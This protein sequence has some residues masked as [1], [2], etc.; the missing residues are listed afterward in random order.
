M[1][2]IWTE[3]YRPET[4]KDV[5]GQDKITN[6]L[7]SFVKKKS[8]PHLMFSGPPGIGKTT[9][10]MCI[11]KDLWGEN[12]KSNF[13]ETNASDERGINVIREKIK[14]NA[15]IKPLASE[16]KIIFLDECDA[17]TKD[18]QQALRR[19]M[20]QYTST[21]R[22]V[23]SCNYSSNII[24]PIQSRCAVF[25]FKKIESKDIAKDIK[26]IAGEENLEIDD[27]AVEMIT[28][29]SEGDIRNAINLLQCTAIEG[30]KIT[31]K[32]VSEISATLM[33][34]EVADIINH[35]LNKDFLKSR[36]ML[37]GMMIEKGI[38][39]FEI[40]RAINRHVWALDIEDELKVKIIKLLGEFEFRIASGGSED[41]QIEA[42]LANLA[43]LK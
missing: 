34:S 36:K 20:E 11:A 28:E 3:K 38:S 41:I 14:Q 15:K 1:N 23:L 22:F 27:D 40:I 13:F 26:N 2:E 24:P 10:A 9:S 8:L 17:L 16:F 42:F 30:K 4:L 43:D 35:A 39:G 7:I 19:V 33:H 21:T 5:I 29:I 6:T 12:W 18:A 31:K 37:M 25:R 32:T